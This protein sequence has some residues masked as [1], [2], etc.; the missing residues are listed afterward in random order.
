M[1][2]DDVEARYILEDQLHQPN[3]MGERFF[4]ISVSPQGLG[5]GRDQFRLC[6]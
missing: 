5:A 6:L 2:M 4:A 1:E 3:V